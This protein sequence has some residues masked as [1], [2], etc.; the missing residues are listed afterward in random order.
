MRT[1]IFAAALVAVLR[2][3]NT[4][5]KPKRFSVFLSDERR[6]GVA[7]GGRWSV[8]RYSED[9]QEPIDSY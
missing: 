4:S 1:A 5:E 6:L 3:G 8:F 9:A 2:V 7:L